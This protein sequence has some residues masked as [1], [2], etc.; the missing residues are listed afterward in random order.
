[1]K[2]FAYIF[3]VSML[4]LGTNPLIRQVQLPVEQTAACC[5]ACCCDTA[6][7]ACS[8]HEQ[9]NED[10]DKDEPC[11]AT[12]DCGCQFHLNALQ[13]Q[14]NNWQVAEEQEYFYGEYHNEYSFEYLSRQIHPPRLV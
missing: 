13:F 7:D 10:K 8:D 5:D 4:I 3:L 14:F 6:E 9:A 2:V 12:C 1:M 11:K